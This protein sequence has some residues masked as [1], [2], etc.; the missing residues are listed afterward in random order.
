MEQICNVCKRDEEDIEKDNEKIV[1]LICDKC[2]RSENFTPFLDK[3]FQNKN[4]L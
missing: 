1:F 3:I 4:C 2:L